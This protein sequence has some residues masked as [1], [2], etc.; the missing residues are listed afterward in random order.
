VNAGEQRFYLRE[1]HP[2]WTP[3]RIVEE[4]VAELAEAKLIE[5]LAHRGSMVRLTREGAR[6]KVAARPET[7]STLPLVRKP[8]H[9]PQNWS[10][11]RNSER[12]PNR[13]NML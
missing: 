7:D 10:A 11:S 12:R 2:Y 5:R 9:P 3:P 8:K 1:I 6:Q 4:R 13:M